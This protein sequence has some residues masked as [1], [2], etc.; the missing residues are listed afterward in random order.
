M[1]TSNRLQSLDAFRGFTMIWMFS[2]SFGLHLFKD[3]P[4]IGPVATQFTHHEWHGTHAWDLIQPFFMFIVGVAM[5]YSFAARDAAGEPWRTQ[6]LHV[7]KRCAILI[8][9]GILARSIR[10]QRP[11]L[12]L[13]NVL[14]QIA[15]T[16]LAAFLVLRFRPAAQA[17][18]AVGLLALHTALYLFLKPEGAATPWL[19]DNNFGQAL[20][21]MFLGKTWGG[22][23]ATINC[24]SSAA[25]TI[26]GVIS[27]QLLRKDEKPLQKLLFW[28]ALAIGAGL[29]LDTMVPAIKKIWTASFAILSLGW[30]LWTLAAFYWVCDVKKWRGWAQPGIIVG[31]NSIFIY[32]FHETT[33]RWLN[34]AARALFGG[35]PQGIAAMLAIWLVVAFQIALCWWLYQRRIFLKI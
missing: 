30:T 6:L 20:D 7:L 23:Y 27:G 5:P 34:H 2:Q 3:H 12:D 33:E 35:D 4:V 17:A 32:V 24:L 13:I 21:L 11:V 22:S 1:Q 19:R 31:A 26:F 25:N 28:G 8:L 14:A 9:L 10:A 18:M 29:A 16:Y 15:F